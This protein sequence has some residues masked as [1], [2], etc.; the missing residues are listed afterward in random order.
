MLSLSHLSRANL[1]AN[2]LEEMKH[3]QDRANPLI[4]E[5]KKQVREERSVQV[6]TDRQT[7]MH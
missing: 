3:L 1:F 2:I 7:H 6:H 4:E 5:Y